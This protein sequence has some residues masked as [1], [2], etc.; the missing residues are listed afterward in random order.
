MLSDAADSLGPRGAVR[1]KDL[2]RLSPFG[3]MDDG[4]AVDTVS[5]AGG[6]AGSIAEDVAH[7]AVAFAAAHLGSD[8]A[9]TGVLDER[10]GVVFH[11]LPE[12]RPATA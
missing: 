3:D 5:V 9:V 4:L 6:G 2:A 8:H 1:A 7:V 11:F 10:E 12:A